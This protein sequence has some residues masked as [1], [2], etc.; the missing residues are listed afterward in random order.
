MF[1]VPIRISLAGLFLAL[2]LT[3]MPGQTETGTLQKEFDALLTRVKASDPTVDFDQLRALSIQVQAVGPKDPGVTLQEI[4]AAYDHGDFKKALQLSDRLL[5]YDYFDLNAQAMAMMAADKLGDKE[6][7]ARHLFVL[8][9]IMNS[10][11][12][13]GDGR[14]PESAFHV[15]AIRE[16]YM[17]LDILEVRMLSQSL[18]LIG[19]H[20]YDVFEVDDPKSD[21]KRTIY[22]NVD[23]IIAAEK[24]MFGN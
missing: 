22:F 5:A 9:G 18:S 14:T 23:P 17:V 15:V 16:E 7:E 4:R 8:K 2:I 20:H 1:N 12:R 11:F 10:I 6:Q 19:G 21:K 13:S 3:P 24:K